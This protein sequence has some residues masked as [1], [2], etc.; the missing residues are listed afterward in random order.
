MNC[1]PVK[2]D[3]PVNWLK[4]QPS[5]LAYPSAERHGPCAPGNVVSSRRVD[6]AGC[7]PVRRYDWPTRQVIAFL[8][9]VV[10]EVLQASNANLQVLIP[11]CAGNCEWI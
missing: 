5:D 4:S 6:G 2:L 10:D 9:V 8:Q 11:G 7:I 3:G 1:V